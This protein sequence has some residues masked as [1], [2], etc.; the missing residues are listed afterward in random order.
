MQANMQM[1]MHMQMLGAGAGAGQQM[2]PPAE[3]RAPNPPK[4]APVVARLLAR[5]DGSLAAQQGAAH[6]SLDAL[7]A[8]HQGELAALQ[9]RQG[10]ELASASRMGV[11]WAAALAPGHEAAT[12]QLLQRQA[13][14]AE[15]FEEGAKAADEELVRKAGPEI[16][17][18]DPI[19]W[20]HGAS[21]RPS[22]LNLRSCSAHPPTHLTPVQPTRPLPHPRQSVRRHK[23]FA[24]AAHAEAMAVAG[25]A[26][27]PAAEGGAPP[28]PKEV[29]VKATAPAAG[30]AKPEAFRAAAAAAAAGDGGDEGDAA[31]KAAHAKPKAA[32]RAA[33]ATSAVPEPAPA[34]PDALDE[35]SAPDALEDAA[36]G[37]RSFS[38]AL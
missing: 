12:G 37:D 4:P 20:A 5:Q 17:A 6:A 29:R 22:A 15:A 21:T 14:A 30:G 2:P 10:D 18:L 11:G 28:A 13:E 9:E 1:Q 24:R 31:P 35:D 36:L 25:G 34:A 19:H 16:F 38:S 27:V 7:Q 3:P 33:A 26:M 23:S 32:R 8:E